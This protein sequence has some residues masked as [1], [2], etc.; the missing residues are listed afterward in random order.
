LIAI[1]RGEG[2]TVRFAGVIAVDDVTFEVGE[3]E[4]VGLIGPNG[5]GKTT[6]VNVLSGFQASK[7]HVRLGATEITD[8]PPHRR[9]R[10]GLRRSF[11][12]ARLFGDL[13]V[14]DNVLVSSL[15]LGL[16]RAEARASAHAALRWS[17]LLADAALPA[18]SLPYGRARWLGVARTLVGTPR[19]VFVDEP[20]AG[21]ND[22]ESAELG[23]ALARVPDEFGCS[24]VLIEHNVALVMNLCDRVH[25]LDNGST[26][27]VGEPASVR[28]LRVVQEAYLGRD[29]G[30]WAC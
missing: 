23:T 13:S 26:I 27:A 8:L 22:V 28:G 14:L 11:Q 21:L 1:L 29:P 24:V 6:L 10:L 5:A 9:A 17:G 3:A 30:V 18:S 19:V 7:G 15:A 25:V 16:P 20:A 2:L 12:N 4:I